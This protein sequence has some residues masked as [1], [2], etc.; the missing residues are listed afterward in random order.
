MSEI[1]LDDLRRLM[2]ASAGDDENVDLDGDILD[3][4]FGELSYDSLAVLEL[5]VQLFQE[6]GIEVDDDVL[7]GLETPRAF[8][9]H[10]NSLKSAAA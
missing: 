5:S 6:Y 9:D 3:R 10:V 1:T 2:R 7:T 8:L 4:S